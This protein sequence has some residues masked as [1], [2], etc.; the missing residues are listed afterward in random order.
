MRRLPRIYAAM[1]VASFQQAAQYRVQAVLW[2]LM[3]VVRPVV[4]LAAWS[5]AANAQGGSIGGFTVGDFAAYYVCLTLVSQLTMA[6]DA[7]DFELEVRQG[8]LAPK[9]LRPLHPV[10]YTVVENIVYK[11]TTLPALLPALVLIAWSF[12][13]HFQTQFWQVIV[14]V[15]SVIA[16]AA[17]RFV[18]GWFIASFAFWTT[19]IHA[20]MHLYDR[21]VFLL[22]GQ[23]APLSL[24]P[25]PLAL[26]SYALPFGYML[27]APAEI[28][29][30]GMSFEQAMLT[31]AAQ[32]VWLAVSTLAYIIVWRLGLRQ[33]SAVGA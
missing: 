4:F 12:E 31:L 27:W 23:V 29:R 20:I 32:A 15:P 19:R 17:L 18:F 14:F 30:G 10:H 7:Y 25:A 26:L 3:A 24:L 33:F 21:L 11:L 28:L 6:W 2:L 16:A 22:A 9:L 5:A 1:F 8:K 13:A